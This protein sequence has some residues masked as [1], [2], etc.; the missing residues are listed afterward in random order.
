M[1]A[2]LTLLGRVTH[3]AALGWLRRPLELCDHTDLFILQTNTIVMDKYNDYNAH[4]LRVQNELQIAVDI[5]H[6]YLK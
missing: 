2:A 3:S 6:K 5:A 1:L 4:H